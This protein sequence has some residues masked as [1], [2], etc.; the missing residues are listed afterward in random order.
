MIYYLH[1]SLAINKYVVCR[2]S[3]IWPPF[4]ILLL[5]LAKMFWV[6][7]SLK[8]AQMVDTIVEH[9][10]KQKDVN[11]NNK[12]ML[13]IKSEP[14][15]LTSKSYLCHPQWLTRLHLSSQKELSPQGTY[16]VQNL[17]NETLAVAD[18]EWVKISRFN[19][20]LLLKEDN[21]LHKLNE[22][23]W[24]NTTSDFNVNHHF[25]SIISPYPGM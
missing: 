3:L 4:L 13:T 16:N 18:H 17:R 15:L 10:C 12:E 23:I 8:R 11:N 9:K 25:F 5:F 6:E 14:K 19:V 21:K 22:W 24:M 1:S 2:C 7:T 20:K